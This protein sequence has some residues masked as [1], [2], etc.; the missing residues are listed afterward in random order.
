M[1]GKRKKLTQILPNSYQNFSFFKPKFTNFALNFLFF[2]L[3]NKPFS[4][5]KHKFVSQ[6]KL[7]LY[8]K[9]RAKFVFQKG[10]NFVSQK[11]KK[12]RKFIFTSHF[13][14]K[15]APHIFVQIHF[16]RKDK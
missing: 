15:I 1:K 5:K 10:V 16:Y 7:N 9:K 14:A 8:I 11:F 6:K 13:F 3:K 12:M 2:I 4:L